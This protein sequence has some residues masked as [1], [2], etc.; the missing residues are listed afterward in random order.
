MRKISSRHADLARLV[1][2]VPI[3]E[4]VIVVGIEDVSAPTVVTQSHAVSNVVVIKAVSMEQLLAEYSLYPA[5]TAGAIPA[6]I[7]G[8]GVGDMGPTPG[9]PVP[10]QIFQVGNSTP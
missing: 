8:V 6:V 10:V 5:C 9:S 2:A 3:V 1:I 4:I 7:A